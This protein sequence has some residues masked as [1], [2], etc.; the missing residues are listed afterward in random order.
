MS[1][2]VEYRV[3]LDCAMKRVSLKIDDGVEIVIVGELQGY[4]SNVISALVAKRIDFFHEELSGLPQNR[5]AEFR[6]DV[7]PKTALVSIAPYR[8][9][10][11]ELMELKAQL[12]ELLD[13]VFIRPNMS[14]WGAPV[15][16][17]KNKY[18]ATKMC[19]DYQ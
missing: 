7:L 2:M 12:Q 6:I 5:K 16:F 10:S 14:P 9:A 3:N 4:L 17:V 19:V 15:L 11:K 18:G 13:R 8:I 1:W